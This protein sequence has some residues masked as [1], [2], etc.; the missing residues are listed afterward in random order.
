MFQKVLGYHVQLNAN[1]YRLPEGLKG[2][3]EKYRI[4]RD[5]K[6]S[7]IAMMPIGKNCYTF[8]IAPDWKKVPV[9]VVHRGSTGKGKWQV[10]ESITGLG[11]VS[12]Y[13]TRDAAVTAV[14]AALQKV[15]ESSFWQAQQAVCRALRAG[16][17]PINQVEIVG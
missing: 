4:V 15:G 11:I 9:L 2:A 1:A 7:E 14:R 5:A 12:G 13:A 6:E 16:K 3:L 17:V 10:D 8:P